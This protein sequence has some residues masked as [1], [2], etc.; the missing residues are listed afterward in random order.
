MGKSELETHARAVAARQEDPYVL[1]DT[2][3]R[4]LLDLHRDDGSV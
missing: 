4:G 2:L 1:V 3:V